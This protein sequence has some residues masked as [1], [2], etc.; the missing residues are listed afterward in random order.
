VPNRCERRAHRRHRRRIEG[1]VLR[2]D[3]RPGFAGVRP[4]REA[5]RDEAADAG[6]ARAGEQRVGALRPEPVRLREA[7]VEVLEVAQAAERGR[8]VDDRVRPGGDDGI[9]HRGRV[10]QVEHDRLGALLAQARGLLRRTGCADDLV[11]PLEQL[12]DEPGADRAGRP[13]DEDSH[14]SLPSLVSRAKTRRR[15]RL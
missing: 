12:R 7:A 9:A 1:I 3:G 5:L 4:A 14:R 13:C 11:P 8:L 6:L 15:P 10:E 2:L